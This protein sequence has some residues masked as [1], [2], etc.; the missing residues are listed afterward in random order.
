MTHPVGVENFPRLAG[1]ITVRDR[2]AWLSLCLLRAV[3]VAWGHFAIPE[4][5]IPERESIDPE[6][7]VQIA[8]RRIVMV[9]W[10]IVLPAP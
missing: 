4:Y 3:G 8:C 9:P 10:Q 2:D 1:K 5:Q 7:A 6:R